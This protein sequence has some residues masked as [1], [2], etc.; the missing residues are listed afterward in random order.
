[1]SLV[2][3]LESA[4]AVTDALLLEW[5]V[6]ILTSTPESFS[7]FFSHLAIVQGTTGLS[8]F[9]MVTNSWSDSF[10]SGNV[11]DM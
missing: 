2:V 9:I 1:M 3:T 5:A 4:A 7:T 6:N 8:G 11:T 10:L